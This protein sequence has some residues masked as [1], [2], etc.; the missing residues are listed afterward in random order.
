MEKQVKIKSLDTKE[1][2]DIHSDLEN[3]VKSDGDLENQTKNNE[4]ESSNWDLEG[5]PQNKS[6]QSSRQL[7]EKLC[8]DAGGN[9]V[10]CCGR[11]WSRYQGILLAFLSAILMTSYTTMIKLLQEMDSMQVFT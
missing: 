6:E 7:D 9:N 8:T 11:I 1:N 10:S 5:Q 4:L 3:Q 2:G